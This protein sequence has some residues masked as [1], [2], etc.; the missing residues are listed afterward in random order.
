MKIPR[1]W[2]VILTPSWTANPVSD[3]EEAAQAAKNQMIEKKYR[4]RMEAHGVTLITMIAVG[5]KGKECLVL[6]VE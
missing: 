1:S 5:F 6:E 3:L 2:W 4:R